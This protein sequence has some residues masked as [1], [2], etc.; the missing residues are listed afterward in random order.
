[1]SSVT[2]SITTCSS[3]AIRGTQ[4]VSTNAPLFST[5]MRGRRRTKGSFGLQRGKNGGGL[6]GRGRMG[7]G[8]RLGEKEL[9]AN[10]FGRYL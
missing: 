2:I 10:E 9:A 5:I 6:T 3:S 7:A 1:M 8:D 4:E